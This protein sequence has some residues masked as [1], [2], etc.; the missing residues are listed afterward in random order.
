MKNLPYFD[1]I[2]VGQTHVPFGLEA[3]TSSRFLPALERSPN[4]DAFYQEF[5]PGIF[6]N[7]TFCDQRITTQSMF[8]KVDAFSQFN[9]AS[10]GDGRYAYSGR[11]SCL[12]YYECEGRELVHLGLAYQ[13]RNASSPLDFDG[14]RVPT[15]VNPAVTDRVDLVR[16]RARQ[17]LRDAVGLQGNN[18][19]VVDTGD[20]IADHVQSL[21]GELMS[22]WG[23]VWLQSEASL[24]F[25]RNAFSR[26]PPPQRRAA[27]SF[28][29][30]PM[31]NAAGS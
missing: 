20:I 5:A 24:A 17:G 9:G 7:M 18:A 23:P 25:T 22:Y 15:A 10:F 6:T 14:G 28:I 29:T 31:P 27:T 12:P 2:R 21:N 8:H 11:V 26:T 1:T 3:Y 4:F 13:W 30:A 16:F 19:R